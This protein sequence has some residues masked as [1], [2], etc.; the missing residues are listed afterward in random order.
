[1]QII[2]DNVFLIC[3]WGFFCLIILIIPLT[4]LLRYMTPRLFLKKYFCKPY[5]TNFE[6][7]LFSGIPYYIARTMILCSGINFPSRIKKGRGIKNRREGLPNWFIW[8]NRIFMGWFFVHGGGTM[9]I[10]IWLV[11]YA[12]LFPFG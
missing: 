2:Y 4:T 9:L 7:Q 3:F 8:A 11:L 6:T 1:M 12:W 5:F 10:L